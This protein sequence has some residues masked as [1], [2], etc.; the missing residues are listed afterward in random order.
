MGLGAH[1]PE[2]QFQFYFLLVIST[3]IHCEVYLASLSFC[4][5]VS[6]RGC[7]YITVEKHQKKISLLIQKLQTFLL[8]VAGRTAF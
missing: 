1:S 6:K 8:F 7:L 2:L 5:L 3:I 4:F